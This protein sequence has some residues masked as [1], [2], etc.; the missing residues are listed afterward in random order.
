MTKRVVL[1]GAAAIA[2][3]VIIGS[4]FALHDVPS[5][6][7]SVALRGDTVVARVR[8]DTSFGLVPGKTLVGRHI[9]ASESIEFRDGESVSLS[10]PRT[11][12]RITCRMSPRPAG[13]Y[14]EGHWFV[15]NYVR[16][17]EKIWFVE[18][19]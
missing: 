5:P 18:A 8:P 12:Y 6:F 13:L 3:I 17:A 16:S 10:S 14:I 9:A 1:V 4:W 11:A 15:H 7:V 2:S 19:R